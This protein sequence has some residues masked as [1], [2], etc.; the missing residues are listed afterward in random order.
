MNEAYSLSPSKSRS[1]MLFV[2]IVSCSS[3][4]S[5]YLF[6]VSTEKAGRVF[7][8]SP[9]LLF[10]HFPSVS[11]DIGTLSL[12]LYR[13]RAPTIKLTKLLQSFT[14]HGES[15]NPKTYKHLLSTFGHTNMLEN[16][17]RKMVEQARNKRLVEDFGVDEL[18]E[19][20]NYSIAMEE[21]ELMM[22][23]C[24][25]NATFL[26]SY[27]SD[28]GLEPDI[29]YGAIS[30]RF[31]TIPG[32][33]QEAQELG[34]AH[35]WVFTKG[36]HLDMAKETEGDIYVGKELPKNYREFGYVSPEYSQ[37]I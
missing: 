31:G 1:L 4:C 12:A 19:N 35:F 13:I 5:L 14:I 7:G 21:K 16:E 23:R 25:E 9:I 2:P 3:L 32:N 34:C 24:H 18:I 20:P 30:D 33:F 22:G 36:Y 6:T 10:Y 8:S 27:L 15:I 28:R 26:S 37:I 17:I 29:V 11:I